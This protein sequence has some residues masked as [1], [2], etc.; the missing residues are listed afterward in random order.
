VAQFLDISVLFPKWLEYFSHWLVY[1][2][3]QPIKAN[4][5]TFQGYTHPLWWPHPVCWVCFSLN[6]ST[7]YLSL[8]LSMD[9]FCNET[10]RT[11]PSLGLETR[12]VIS[13]RRLW[14]LARSVSQLNGLKSQSGFWLGSS[15]STWVQDPIW[16]E[17]FHCVLGSA[18]VP[19]EGLC[20]DFCHSPRGRE[21]QPTPVFLPGE[22]QGWGCLV[23][24]RLWG[25][26]E[27]DMTEAT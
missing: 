25:H 17:Q 5:T 9:S 21:W 24:C 20:M 18:N 11:W 2:I 16:G 6:K 7:S 27:S 4:P 1:E 15:P 13:V 19:K 23:G 3:T 22:S 14:V 12:S 10:S 26:T 8:C